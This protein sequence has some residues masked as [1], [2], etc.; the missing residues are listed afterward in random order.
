MYFPLSAVTSLFALVAP[1]GAAAAADNADNAAIGWNKPDHPKL[2]WMMSIM[3]DLTDKTEAEGVAPFVVKEF[4]AIEEPECLGPAGYVD[5]TPNTD[6]AA[7]C[8]TACLPHQV[9][10]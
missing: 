1:A 5:C 9:C 8:K 7:A 6:C 2:D 3:A 10:A 4:D